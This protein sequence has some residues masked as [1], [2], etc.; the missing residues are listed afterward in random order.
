MIGL[1]ANPRYTQRTSHTNIGSDRTDRYEIGSDRIA[2]LV[3]GSDRITIHFIH[4]E[5]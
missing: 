3:L 4:T 1:G 2:I 5:L